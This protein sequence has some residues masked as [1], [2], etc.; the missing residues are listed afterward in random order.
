[1]STAT[2]EGMKESLVYLLVGICVVA[3]FLFFELLEVPPPFHPDH[4]RHRP[5]DFVPGLFF[6]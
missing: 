1:M 3:T 5:A 6:A 4:L 2:D